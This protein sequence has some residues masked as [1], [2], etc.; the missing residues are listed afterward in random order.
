MKKAQ[1]QMQETMLAI[2]I[3]IIILAICLTF[4]YRF[5]SSSIKADQFRYEQTKYYELFSIIPNLP[6]IKCSLLTNEEDCI[7]T[8]KLLSFDEKKYQNLLI[9]KE[10]KIYYQ[11]GNITCNLKNYPNCNSFNIHS[12]K[13]KGSFE[14]FKSPVSLY[15][16]AKDEYKLGIL[17]IKWYQ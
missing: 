12:K 8:T 6:D 14:I 10:I 9:D 1:M 3:F 13:K 16:P 11:D 5:Q 7:D 4:F 2:V 15:F 17:E